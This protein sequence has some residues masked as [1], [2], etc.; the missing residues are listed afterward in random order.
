[1]NEKKELTELE[2]AIAKRFPNEEYFCKILSTNSGNTVMIFR[3][4]EEKEKEYVIIASESL[5]GF[6]IYKLEESKSIK[7]LEENG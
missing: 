7:A 2:K 3:S 1:M 4:N 6:N 5:K